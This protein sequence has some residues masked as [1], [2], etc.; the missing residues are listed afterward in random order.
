[1]SRA[2]EA[3]MNF[4]ESPLELPPTRWIK[5]HLNRLF[6]SRL[7]SRT[8]SPL[9][10][11]GRESLSSPV[12]GEASYQKRR[13]QLLLEVA[14]TIGSRANWKPLFLVCPVGY[15]ALE[16]LSR[17]LS[18]LFFAR[19]SSCWW[20][21]TIRSN[22]QNSFHFSFLTLVLTRSNCKLIELFWG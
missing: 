18:S 16:F 13:R 20:I 4:R 7:Y 12:D 17:E 3:P 6:Y 8:S 22:N 9:C 2:I 11:E 14:K 10:F 15:L 21:V 19:H 5:G 1:M